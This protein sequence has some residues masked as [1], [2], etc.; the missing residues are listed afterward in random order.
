MLRFFRQI[1]QRLLT[2]N[3]F[4]KY[5]L[6]AVGEI[7]LVVIGILIALQIDN[8]NEEKKEK[9]RLN[10]F[11]TEIQKDL[12]DDI[13]KANRIIDN[14]IV[15]D[16]M[17]RNTLLGNVSLSKDRFYERRYQVMI[18]YE[19]ESFRLQSK[20]YDGLVQ[21]IDN[22]PKKYE[23]LMENL[24]WVYVTNRYDLE[25]FNERVKENTYQNRDKLKSKNWSGDFF[26]AQFKEDM[27]PY[28]QSDSY[29]NE[30]I[31]FFDDLEKF[32]RQTMDFKVAAIESYEEIANLLPDNS[33]LPEHISY[34]LP[35]PEAL[36]Q[37][38][39]E[40]QFISSDDLE[41]DEDDSM[42]FVIEDQQLYW[43]YKYDGLNTNEEFKVP[44]YWHKNQIFFNATQSPARF[45]FNTEDTS[46]VY[47]TIKAQGGRYRYEKVT[48]D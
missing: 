26:Q 10:D 45:E 31:H 46:K 43:D 12:S 2:D 6:Y 44:F 33:P 5:L 1:R 32:I 13:L 20:G 28:F 39:G 36:S 25:S 40:Y 15:N 35:D 7:L 8:W 18:T 30:A 23:E 37:L 34:T 16:S 47:L 17:F 41:L 38:A 19:F 24:N 9:Q 3:K 14:H 27:N 29:R 11:L 42:V 21:N 4:S 48:E 22:I